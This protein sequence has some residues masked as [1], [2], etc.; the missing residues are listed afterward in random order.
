MVCVGDDISFGVEDDLPVNQRLDD[1]VHLILHVLW[2]NLGKRRKCLRLVRK[3]DGVVLP[4][5]RSG[6][7]LRNRLGQNVVHPLLVRRQHQ[8]RR[9]MRLVARPSDYPHISLRLRRIDRTHV[10]IITVRQDQRHPAVDLR[11]GRFFRLR[12]VHP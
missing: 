8:P 7:N 9:Q 4:L 11:R 3:P 2:H 12:N 10:C 6:L 1:L 5:D